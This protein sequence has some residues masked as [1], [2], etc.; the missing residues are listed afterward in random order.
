MFGRPLLAVIFTLGMVLTIARRPR[1]GP[2]HT[3]A[4]VIASAFFG[5][6]LVWLAQSLDAAGLTS[7]GPWFHGH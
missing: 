6:A 7:F 1:T 3:V 5:A 2:G 4:L